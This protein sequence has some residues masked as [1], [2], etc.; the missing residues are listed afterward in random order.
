[1]HLIL[2]FTEGYFDNFHD[3]KSRSVDFFWKLFQNCWEDARVL[4][5]VTEQ[6]IESI[7]ILIRGW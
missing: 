1:M 7:Y 2:A 5:L 3:P 6:N 4:F